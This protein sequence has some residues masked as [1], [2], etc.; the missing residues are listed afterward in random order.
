MRLHDACLKS[1][2]VMYLNWNFNTIQIVSKRSLVNVRL[3]CFAAYSSGKLSLWFLQSIHLPCRLHCWLE[4]Y[5]ERYFTKF[6]VILKNQGFKTRSFIWFPDRH[7]RHKGNKQQRILRTLLHRQQIQDSWGS[8]GLILICSKPSRISR[9]ALSP[10]WPSRKEGAS[11]FNKICSG[12]LI[13][14][15]RIIFP[16]FSL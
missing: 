5:Y 10:V 3:N 6:S 9:R 13:E 7:R 2:W 14:L 12:C 1:V 8:L 15:F 4:W 16:P 11:K